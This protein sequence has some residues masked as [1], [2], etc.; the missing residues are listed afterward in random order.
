MKLVC[1]HAEI[2]LAFPP[3]TSYVIATKLPFYRVLVLISE[4]DKH[5]MSHTNHVY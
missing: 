2:R 4:F 3:M 5:I 1:F